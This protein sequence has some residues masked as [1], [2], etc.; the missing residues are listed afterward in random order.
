MAEKGCINNALSEGMDMNPTLH[1]VNLFGTH[2]RMRTAAIDI[3][4]LIFPGLEHQQMRYLLFVGYLHN[5]AAQ[6]R[7]FE[8]ERIENISNLANHTDDESKKK[9]WDHPYNYRTRLQM[10][11]T[12]S[13]EQ[14][15]TFGD[16]CNEWR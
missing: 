10:L 14:P 1:E 6:A 12:I 4:A 5:F 2:N 8:S 11:S 7:V 3:S 13:Y 9:S 15:Y 16:M